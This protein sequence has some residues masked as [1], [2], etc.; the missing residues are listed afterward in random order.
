MVFCIVLGSVISLLIIPLI[1]LPGLMGSIPWRRRTH[2]RPVPRH[3]GLPIPRHGGIALVLA[4]LGVVLLACFLKP[5]AIAGEYRASFHIVW[6][7]LLITAI[8]IWNDFRRFSTTQL[9]CL[10][11]LVA[12]L[13]FSRGVHIE[14]VNS[15]AGTHLTMQE[16]WSG[17]VTV[18][19]LVSLTNLVRLM[20]S[21]TGLASGI[22]CLAL[23]VLALAAH[24]SGVEFP[25][26][27]AIGMI[28]AVGTFLIYNLPP[29]RIKLGG[30]GA[31]LL[32][33]LVGSLTVLAS[34]EPTLLA[35][36]L[37]PFAIVTLLI[38]GAAFAVL[39]REFQGPALPT[40]Q[41]QYSRPTFPQRGVKPHAS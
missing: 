16:L 9:L 31:S 20:D 6:A 36:S 32:G 3:R 15:H 19:W 8:G 35:A 18:L 1:L 12:A 38:A 11:A 22:S 28:G 21:V 14:S 37:A 27:C 17:C 39:R 26:Y 13:L 30:G 7:T 33:F 2:N 24:S 29:A 4:F 41:K 5:Q 25:A 34:H 10:Q 23:G 40:P